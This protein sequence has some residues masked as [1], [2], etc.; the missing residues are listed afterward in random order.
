MFVFIGDWFSDRVVSLPVLS[1]SDQKSFRV[2]SE[3]STDGVRRHFPA[4]RA[5]ALDSFRFVH[6]NPKILAPL[7]SF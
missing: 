1:R 7:F 2:F 6:T 5:A 4:F 3:K